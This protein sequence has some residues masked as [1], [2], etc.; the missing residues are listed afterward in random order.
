MMAV[1][2]NATSCK[3][4]IIMI[5]AKIHYYAYSNCYSHT[6]CWICYAY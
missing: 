3:H 6:L 2:N 5:I 4:I 1:Y